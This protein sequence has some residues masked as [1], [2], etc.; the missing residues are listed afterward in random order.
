MKLMKHI[1][2]ALVLCAIPAVAVGQTVTTT[3]DECTH[4]VSVYMGEG[5]FIANAAEGAEMVTWVASCGGVTRTGELTPN[6][7][8]VSALLA[9]NLACHS[10]GGSFELGPIMDGGWYWLTMENN[11]A[12]GGL[13]AKNILMNANTVMPT[14][15]GDSVTVTE[16]AGAVLLQHTSG[17]VGILPTILPVMDVAPEMATPCGFSGAGTAASAYAR[18]MGNCMM[19]DGGTIVLASTYDGFSGRNTYHAN[20]EFT[21]YRPAGTATASV[22]IDLWGNGSGHFTT[23][24]TADAAVVGPPAIPAGINFLRGQPSVAKTA[25]RELTRY[26]GV[27]YTVT[28]GAGLGGGSTITAGTP[29]QG[30]DFIVADNA[31][32]VNVVANAANCSGAPA[33]NNYSTPVTVNAFVAAADDTGQGQVTPSIK[34]ARSPAGLAGQI[35][36]TVMCPAASAN[37]GQ[38]LVPENPFPTTE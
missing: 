22:V 30:V 33:N 24:G 7:G 10:E 23:S 26:Q 17:H 18:L 13:V 27:T 11:S 9:G 25:L 3:C 21:V 29:V 5:G 38:E 19:G 16:G 35:K 31:V 12:V 1:T 32:T 28:A 8:V 14:D 15:A 2:I 34:V 20:E 4:Q 37:M 36:F 6:D